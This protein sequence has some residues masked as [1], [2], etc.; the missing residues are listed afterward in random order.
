MVDWREA[1]FLILEKDEGAVVP[2]VGVRGL[3]PEARG[4]FPAGLWN[5][6]PLLTALAARRVHLGLVPAEEAR[7]ALDAR[8]GQMF[9]LLDYRPEPAKF[10]FLEGLEWEC[11]YYN[12]IALIDDLLRQRT[13]PPCF[14]YPILTLDQVI[15]LSRWEHVQNLDLFCRL[16][17][18]ELTADDW[19]LILAGRRLEGLVR[20]HPYARLTEYR[21]AV[22]EDTDREKLRSL[23]RHLQANPGPDGLFASVPLPPWLGHT[24]QIRSPR[25]IFQIRD[26][27]ENLGHE[28]LSNCALG[29][30]CLVETRV[31]E[32][33]VYLWVDWLG[34]YASEMAVDQAIILA[35]AHD[36]GHR[37][38]RS[39]RTELEEDHPP[40]LL[41]DRFAIV[42]P[43]KR[44][45]RGKEAG[46]PPG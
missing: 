20:Q 29:E 36:Q 23:E 15:A 25:T 5:K 39:I 18:Q 28:A 46:P 21:Q 31:A 7:S 14:D 16:E 44:R 22:H 10:R 19:E 6:R 1:D 13:L 42:R 45:R 40:Q 11:L 43:G 35:E 32:R 17:E 24:Q 4:L 27:A 34:E 2:G 33:T 8:D 9:W 30:N 26:Q 3:S 41:P 37:L 38:I 12:D